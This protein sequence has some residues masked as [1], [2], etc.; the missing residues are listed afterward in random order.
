MFLLYTHKDAKQ[1]FAL[2]K[3]CNKKLVADTQAQYP[4][5]ICA[6]NMFTQQIV[7]KKRQ[8]TQI[9]WI[10]TVWE[11]ATLC[12]YTVYNIPN[13]AQHISTSLCWN[14]FFC[15]VESVKSKQV[16]LYCI[17]HNKRILLKSRR[18]KSVYNLSLYVLGLL[19]RSL[20]ICHKK[21]SNRE[22]KIGRVLAHYALRRLTVNHIVH[23]R[24]LND[25]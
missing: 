17:L 5:K 21:Q 6:A 22:N 9:L 8:P 7:S 19:K 10:K 18:Q 24:V 16:L 14:V 3:E 4:G 15:R 20:C 13:T 12:I 25:L 11:Y 23:Q 2:Q 1:F